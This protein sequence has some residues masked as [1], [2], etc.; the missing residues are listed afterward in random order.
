ME[1]RQAD[2]T[3]AEAFC[4][5]ISRIAD[6]L[7]DHPTGTLKRSPDNPNLTRAVVYNLILQ[8]NRCRPVKVDPMKFALELLSAHRGLYG[9]PVAALEG[10][11][12]HFNNAFFGTPSFCWPIM[13]GWEHTWHVI[14]PEYLYPDIEFVPTREYC[15]MEDSKFIGIRAQTSH[16]KVSSMSVVAVPRGDSPA[17]QE[18][19]ER[20]INREERYNFHS[21]LPSGHNASIQLEIHTSASKLDY[22]VH[23]RTDEGFE[24]IGTKKWKSA[25]EISTGQVLALILNKDARVIKNVREQSVQSSPID[26][27]YQLETCGHEIGM[28]VTTLEPPEVYSSLA[29]GE[30]ISLTYDRAT[31]LALV[32]NA[33]ERKR[34]QSSS[35]VH[36]L[37]DC[38][39]LIP[40]CDVFEADVKMLI[41]ENPPEYQSI[42]LVSR[43]DRTARCVSGANPF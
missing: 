32:R 22:C 3:E 34:M 21:R 29:R 23:I 7:A 37:L 4:S 36:L 5:D 8:R 28:Q 17:T 42:W 16:K 15:L 41:A 40:S 18:I 6:K 10:S 12:E 43:V 33:L 25:R 39:F 26:L 24:G 38:G 11:N 14:G 13:C 31:L 1:F 30:K 9:G 19:I 27:W 35:G 2:W 20:S